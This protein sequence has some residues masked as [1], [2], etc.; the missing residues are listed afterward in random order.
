MANWRSST[1]AYEKVRGEKQCYVTIW[2]DMFRQSETHEHAQQLCVC[3]Q[4]IA[5]QMQS[6]KEKYDGSF[7]KKVLRRMKLLPNRYG[8][9]GRP[10]QRTNNIDELFQLAQMLSFDFQD[11]VN[12]WNKVGYVCP[13]PVKTP[14]RALQKVVRSYNRD[15]ACLTD[16]VRCTI[17]VGSLKEALV[18]LR[19]IIS[20]S[21]I[22][23]GHTIVC[24]KTQEK[25]LSSL[26]T[27]GADAP[28]SET[29]GHQ[30]VSTASDVEY[31]ER[32]GTNGP[33]PEIVVDDA[34]G[35]AAPYTMPW[36]DRFT[37]A[38]TGL[39]RAKSMKNMISHER[40]MRIMYIRNRF[41]PKY[42]ASDSQGYRH[43]SMNVEVCWI[44]QPSLCQ[45]LPVEEWGSHPE[46][47][48]LVCEIQILL[49]PF[50]RIVK[51]QGH[52]NYVEYRNT[53]VK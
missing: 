32:S 40:L 48:S 29:N 49:E 36:S 6:A 7:S 26:S 28:Q 1:N 50:H 53:L 27:R 43:I 13:G 21:E 42:D 22:V 37:R 34:K 46:A 39:D 24:F 4:R 47:Q 17:V 51:A 20:K 5:D 3:V 30:H 8:E 38:A 2:Q 44:P 10:K 12:S 23:D 16:L 41:D 33:E 52:Q 19:N 15:P 31:S 45:F 11:W 9:T 14:E 18:C 35:S 25:R